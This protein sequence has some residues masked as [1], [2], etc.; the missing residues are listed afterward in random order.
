MVQATV[1]Q[2][3]DKVQVQFSD[4]P[5]EGV[6]GWLK[7]DWRFAFRQGVWERPGDL[8]MSVFLDEIRRFSSVQWSFY[9]SD[10]ARLVEARPV[11]EPGKRR[12]YLILNDEQ[13]KPEQAVR[14]REVVN[15]TPH[16]INI[17]GIVIQPSGQVARVAEV[18]EPRGVIELGSIRIPVITKRFGEVE[19][20][21][22]PQD[23]VIY[24]VSALT[25][26]A[27]WAAG[28]TDVFCPGDLIR[29]ESGRVV[30]AAAL[31]AAPQCGQ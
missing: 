14:V 9:V 20:L 4:V 13:P 28:R 12:P 2:W 25:A 23:G 22:E 18:G 29:D 8:N 7:R 30:G 27:A 24:I 15:L 5:P 16:P 26:Q 3:P 31:C 19:G 1:I 11:Y 21:P 17:G 6:R 10:G